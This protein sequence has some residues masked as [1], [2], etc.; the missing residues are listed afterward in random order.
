M[1]RLLL[2]LTF[3][4]CATAAH[5]QTYSFGTITTTTQ[6]A[7]DNSTN[8][9]TTAYVTTGIANAIA[10]VNPAVATQAATNAILPNSPIYNNGVAGIGAT[11][12]TATLNTPLVVDGYTPVLNDRILVKNEA[13]GGGLGASRNGVYTV[14]QVSGVGLAWILTRA[15]DFDA[16][17]DMNNSGAIPVVNGT[18]NASTQWLL[19]SKVNTVG[20]DAV[21][22]AQ[23]SVSPSSVVVNN[24]ANTGT[25][26]MTL[27]M[28]ASAPAGLIVPTLI[29][30]N[31]V[32]TGGAIQYAS[33][34]QMYIFGATGS[35]NTMAVAATGAATGTT[36]T[37]Q[38][39]TAVFGTTGPTCSGLTSA[40]VNGSIAN[41][42]TGAFSTLTDGA[43]ITWAIASAYEA[44]AGVT[45]GGNRTLNITNPVNGGTYVLKVI[46]DGT[47]S[48]TLALG[49]GCTWKVSGGGAGTITLS[50][51][52]NAIDVLT[53]S[54][55]GANCLAILTK[56]FN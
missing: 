15:L 42:T 4:L 9:A 11:I 10:A 53:W 55:D 32:S 54:Y 36:C 27:N 8:A 24:A 38:V 37:N 25:S 33:D 56:N 12:T 50:T 48:R 30:S 51:A 45:L 21:T 23:F 14:T 43:T 49:T 26:A 16:P 20:T 17:S 19:T 44:N 29:G 7:T 47:G 31:S 34:V 13:G 35:R 39:V 28:S 40:Y 6:A 1:K 18:A 52:A 3:F 22:F 2:G 5:A 46:Q 41:A